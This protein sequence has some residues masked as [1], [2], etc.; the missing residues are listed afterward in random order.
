M[1]SSVAP[2]VCV[3]QLHHQYVGKKGSPANEALRGI[4]LDIPAGEIVALLGPNGSGKT[5][6]FR[7]IC[8][9]LPVQSGTVAVA[10]FDAKQNPL[11]V[12]AN[13]GI[14]FQSPSLDK[15]LTV[16]ENIACQAALYG[17]T[18]KELNDRRDEVLSLL[19]LGDRRSALC[20]TLSGGLKR[21]VELA[22]GM[23]HRPPLML[24]DEPSTGLDPSARLSLWDAIKAMAQQ[25][26]TVLLTTHLL[27]EADKAD[28]VAIL[29]EGRK[30][31]EGSPHQLRSEMGESVVTISSPDIA[32]TLRVLNEE[33]GL[34]AKLVNH[35]IRFQSENPSPL[36]PELMDRLGDA[37][38]SITVGRPSLED[39]F[40]AK[41]GLRFDE[42]QS[43]KVLVGTSS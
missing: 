18:G 42:S 33:F 7:L 41:T 31:A 16:D 37:M 8:T 30:I 36:L 29:C 17:I 14:V 10:G 12:R 28:R 24:L 19:D 11:A 5:T 2:V 9:L 25:G 20:E 3:R 43:A 23:L 22:K 21:R 26:T 34:N 32:G 1:S 39:V 35:Q 4:D 38:E 6:L 15:K 13:I 40:V 27:E